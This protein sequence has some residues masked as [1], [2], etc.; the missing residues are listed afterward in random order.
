MNENVDINDRINALPMVALRGRVVFPDTN[1]SFDV[2]RP[3]SLAAV[4]A[5][6]DGNLDLFVAAQ[7]NE[8]TENPSAEDIYKFGTVVKIRQIF[9]NTSDSVRLTVQGISRAKI[10]AIYE[11]GDYL[12]ADVEEV[13]AVYGDETEVEG[14]YRA[15]LE[16]LKEFTLFDSKIAADIV[17]NLL[18]VTEPDA[19]VNAVSTQMN[20]KVKDKE[21]ILEE[22]DVCLR[23]KKLCAAL[24]G[25]LEII[26]VEKK[27]SNDV[28]KSIDKSQKEY[29]LREQ[30]KAIH[31][32]LGDDVQE[33]AMLEEK[34]KAKK[35]PPEICEKAIKEIARLD[36]M[37]PSS[38]EA[39]V[40]RNYLDLLIDLPFGEMTQDN[41][42]LNK[43]QEILDG[44]HYGLEKVKERVVEYLAVLLLTKSLK[45]PI[46]C[47][48]G[49]PGVG[50]TSIAQSIARA[51]NRKFVRMSLGGIKDESEIR[52]HRRTYIGAMPGR[53]I[54]HLRNVGANNPVFLLDEIDKI[55][56]DMRGDPASALLEVLDPEQN[57]TFRDRFLEEP[58]DL[59]H[60]MFITT[61]NS[62][63]TIPGPLLD[64]M[65][66]IELSG[67]TVQEKLEIAKRYLLPK[68]LK[69]HGLT[70]DNLEI[71]DDGFVAVI[72]N[73]TMEAGV[74]SLEREIAGICRKY[75]V[76]YAKNRSLEKAVVTRDNLEEYL[77]KVKYIK[78][79]TLE[80]D[81]VGLANG[82][83]WTSVGGTTL[84]IEVNLMK[85]KGEVLLTGKL[86]DVMK[87]SART[88]LSYIRANAEKFGIDSEIFASTD[89][90]LHVPEGATPKD[91]P[92]AGI[93][94]ATAMLSA[95]TD[96]KVRSDV[97]MTGEIT[98]RGRVLPIGGVKEKVLAAARCG[99]KT[100]IM[101]KENA[102]DMDE[103]PQN[104][105]ERVEFIF[106]DN[107]T[108]VFSAAIIDL[109]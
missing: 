68:K 43:A 11:E 39:T 58:Y 64:R 25:E 94:I 53:I 92:S 108:Q 79:K 69:E 19:F 12:R 101:P 96:K 60:I 2:G 100:V 78:D 52:G 80:E 42:D 51:L 71:T 66:I 85:G 6:S 81:S 93:T 5:A 63:E 87:E 65:E 9:K 73:Y 32:E 10:T 107:V 47:F 20:F 28:R 86:G 22:S 27:I 104:V 72:E 38:P 106:A 76:K 15:A 49:P 109:N 41:E 88:A 61:A 99:I 50:K 7:V 56:S 98:L 17:K 34:I 57:S 36:K 26:K 4:K 54:Y 77:G 55:S 24:L 45:G 23:L 40:I 95:F 29:F 37:P 89:I 46:L 82:L 83:A 16:I 18:Q 31:T 90:H 48:V 35:M 74:R 8:K 62:M 44:D 30:I 1:T 14:H 70:P 105:Q 13:S 84:T 97:A 3:K 91:G 21:D 102:K 59:S 103:I 33:K 75:A 67:Y